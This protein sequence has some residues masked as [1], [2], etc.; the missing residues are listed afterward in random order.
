MFNVSIYSRC[1]PLTKRRLI[2]FPVLSTS[3]MK[4]ATDHT[5]NPHE[6]TIAFDIDKSYN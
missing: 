1:K 6:D 5:I 2:I 4:P 3:K